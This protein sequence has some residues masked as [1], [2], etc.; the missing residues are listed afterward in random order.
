MFQNLTKKK[1]FRP[2]LQIFRGCDYQ[3]LHIFSFPYF[4]IL[5]LGKVASPHTETQDGVP[6]TLNQSNTRIRVQLRQQQPQITT[7]FQKMRQWDINSEK[8]KEIHQLIGEMIAT[9]NQPFS[10]CSDIGFTCLP[11]PYHLTYFPESVVPKFF[12]NANL[13][14]RKLPMTR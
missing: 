4:F 14:Y 7:T 1:L 12:I 9:D 2:F 6:S 10:I 11:I 5:L 13:A 8:A 3:T